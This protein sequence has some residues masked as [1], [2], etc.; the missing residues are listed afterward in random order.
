MTSNLTG[1]NVE[2]DLTFASIKDQGRV[3]SEDEK[4][5]HSCQTNSQREHIFKNF[6]LPRGSE[7]SE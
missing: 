6:I 4:R 1:R 7:R 3:S 2:L 5:V